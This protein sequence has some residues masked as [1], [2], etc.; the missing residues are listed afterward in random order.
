VEV[1]AKGAG[2]WGAFDYPYFVDE[3]G[4]TYVGERVSQDFIDELER[5]SSASTPPAAD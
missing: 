5:T 2:D 3:V 1:F 4:R